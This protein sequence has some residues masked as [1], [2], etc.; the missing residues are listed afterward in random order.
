MDWEGVYLMETDQ[1]GNR[2]KIKINDEEIY[3][4]EVNGIDVQ[5]YTGL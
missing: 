5:K 1:L 2:K 3:F 4:M